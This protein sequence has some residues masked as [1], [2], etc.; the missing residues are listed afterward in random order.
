[1]NCATNRQLVRTRLKLPL[2][3]RTM[4]LSRTGLR[5]YTAHTQR[6]I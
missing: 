6:T 5:H 2:G 3:Y 4:S 1:M